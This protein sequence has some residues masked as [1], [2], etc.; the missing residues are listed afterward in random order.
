[1]CIYSKKEEKIMN[2]IL[3]RLFYVHF[4]TFREIQNSITVISIINYYEQSLLKH[5][6]LQMFLKCFCDTW[7][8][9]RSHLLAKNLW[10]CFIAMVTRRELCE[11]ISDSKMTSGILRIL[12]EVKILFYQW[13]KKVWAINTFLSTL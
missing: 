5:F 1:M 3:K 11:W 13:K 12:R 6:S 9:K 8:M 4:E 7:R 2:F 10:S